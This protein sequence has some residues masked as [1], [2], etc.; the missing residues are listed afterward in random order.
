MMR[1][2][3]VGSPS[4]KLRKSPLRLFQSAEIKQHQA[5]LVARLIVVGQC[6]GLVERCQRLSRPSQ[7]NQRLAFHQQKAAQ[8]GPLGRACD[9]AQW[10]LG[11]SRCGLT[12]RTLPTRRDLG[13]RTQCSTWDFFALFPLESRFSVP[14]V[15]QPDLGVFDGGGQ[16]MDVKLGGPGQRLWIVGSQGQRM[17]KGQLGF[18]LLPQSKQR[19]RSVV[20]RL[21]GQLLLTERLFGTRQ[22]FT[23]QPRRAIFGVAVLTNP[24]CLAGLLDPIGGPVE[25][26][27]QR[28]WWRQC[29]VLG[30]AALQRR[31][32]LARFG[33]SFARACDGGAWLGLGDG[34]E[35]S[36]SLGRLGA[37]ARRGRSRR[38]TSIAPWLAPARR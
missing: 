22:R 34:S 35:G 14:N 25:Q 11:A 28:A 5:S 20:M 19:Q 4:D 10:A 24:L 30:K 33:F 3:V 37:T 23:E 2:R 7:I 26:R 29:G 38:T 31:R 8:Q 1:P 32:W 6:D 17:G 27:L 18:V 36:L 16:V 15:G 21:D 9:R 12:T 13:G